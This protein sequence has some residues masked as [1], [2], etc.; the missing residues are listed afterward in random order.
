YWHCTL[1]TSS[2]PSPATIPLSSSIY[3][4]SLH[5]ALPIFSHALPADRQRHARAAIID[6]GLR[7]GE[8][9]TVVRRHDDDRVVELTRAFECLDDVP[10]IS[11]ESLNL[12]IVVEQILPHVGGVGQ[13]WRDLNPFRFQ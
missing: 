12:E 6:V 8:R 11:I 3:L 13:V 1:T 9:H 7:A 2:N 4:L 10:K 5:D